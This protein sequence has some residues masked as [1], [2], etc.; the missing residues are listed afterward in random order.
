MTGSENNWE[1]NKLQPS[2]G[3]ESF[4]GASIPT[5]PTIAHNGGVSTSFSSSLFHP[6][7]YIYIYIYRCTY[8]GIYIG[9]RNARLKKNFLY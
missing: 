9:I 4:A 8:I 5:I 2:A 6:Y 3:D 1:I 7:I